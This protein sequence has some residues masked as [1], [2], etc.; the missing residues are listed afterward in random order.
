MENIDI[1]Q[2]QLQQQQIQK[3]IS[4]SP[5]RKCSCGCEHFDTATTQ[6]EVSSLLSGTGK[7]EI[8]LVGV[9]V[10]RK[11]GTEVQKPLI[12]A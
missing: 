6:V 9:L 7:N 4:E 8:L 1:Q 3:I 2:Q 5:R 10:C 12:T 11:C